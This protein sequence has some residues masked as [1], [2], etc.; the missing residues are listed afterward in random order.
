MVRHRINPRLVKIHRSYTVDEHARM[1]GTHKNTVRNWIR[2]GLPLI[3]D[4]RP[5]LI[6]GRDLAEFL[7]KRCQAAKHP[8]PTGYLFCLKCRTPKEPAGQMAE[9]VSVTPT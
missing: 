1:L 5:A 3:D 4:Q 8:C 9:Y 7:R 6:Q 2:D